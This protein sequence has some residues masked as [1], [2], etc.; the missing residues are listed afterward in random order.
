MIKY[1]MGF[2]ILMAALLGGLLFW[3][4]RSSYPE[5]SRKWNLG[6]SCV[7]FAIIASAAAWLP[8]LLIA[9]SVLWLTRPIETPAYRMT[10]AVVSSLALGV[11]GAGA[12]E[13][14]VIMSVFS[15]DLLTGR[16]GFLGHWNRLGVN[17]AKLEA[18]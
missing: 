16:Q 4:N 8:A 1:W 3:R 7:D 9:W 12:M 10:M 13:A 14:I 5:K 15:I 17:P 2:W 6:K 11:L 18:A